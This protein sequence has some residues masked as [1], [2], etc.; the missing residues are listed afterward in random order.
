MIKSKIINVDGHKCKLTLVEGVIQENDF[1]ISKHRF[2]DMDE[3]GIYHCVTFNPFDV[4]V[5]KVFLINIGTDN[6]PEMVLGFPT[7]GTCD[8]ALQES[9]SIVNVELL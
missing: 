1:V 4:E 2:I 6:N 9:Y 8:K 7:G 3:N 5:E